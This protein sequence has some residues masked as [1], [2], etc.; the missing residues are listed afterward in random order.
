MVN[1]FAGFRPLLRKG[2][3]SFLIPPGFSGRS[4]LTPHDYLRKK[5]SNLNANVEIKAVRG[6][7]YTLEEKA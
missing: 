1:R 3:G 2:Y 4:E 7:G 5:L 6:V